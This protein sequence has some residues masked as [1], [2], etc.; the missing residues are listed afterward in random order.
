M[1]EEKL[2]RLIEQGAARNFRAT[3]DLHQT[4]FHQILQHAVNG[5]SAN[6]FDVGARDRLAIRDDGQ[7]FERRRSKPRR[8]HCR[9]QL[10]DPRRVSR[11]AHQLPA[12]RFL[13]ELE[14]AALLDVLDLQSFER[15]GHLR[16]SRFRELVRQQLIVVARAFDGGSELA[17]SQRLLRGEQERFYH[18]GESHTS[19][20]TYRTYSPIALWIASA[21]RS[22][23]RSISSSSRPSMS[24]RIFG[25]VP[26]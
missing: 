9:E 11:I 12:F 18:L 17:R 5:D 23:W 16:L 19:D 15:G 6:R 21:I 14:G 26:E 24:S 2:G 20:A 3:G 25:S 4:A 13:R 1:F 7:G 10:P 8:F 22:A